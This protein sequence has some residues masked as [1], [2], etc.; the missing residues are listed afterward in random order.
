MKAFV[1]SVIKGLEKEREVVANAA[2]TLDFEVLRSEDFGALESSSQE[3]CLRGVRE[4]DVVL[5]ILGER[6]GRPQSSGRSATHEEYLEAR[7]RKPILA[8]VQEGVV[9]ED[10]QATLMREVEGWENG[11]S[12][13]RFRDSEDLAVKATQALH[14]FAVRSNA[15]VPDPAEALAR[16]ESF[17]AS[18]AN[19]SVPV[20]LVAVAGTTPHPIVRPSTLDDQKFQ[21]A[22]MREAQ[23][24]EPPVLCSGEGVE[25]RITG[26][27]LRI[28]QTNGQVLLSEDGSIAIIRP[29][30]GNERGR[31]G[32]M[33][34][35][36]EEDLGDAI[37]DCLKF[38]GKQLD[39]LDRFKRMQEVVILAGVLGGG[40]YGWQTRAEHQTSRGGIAI[41]MGGD[42]DRVLV[43]LMPAARMRASLTKQT[44]ELTEDLLALLRRRLR[45]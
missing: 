14:R 15:S 40:Y 32:W 28:E 1:S 39:A 42:R 21:K 27:V 7:E 18:M 4:A 22:I 38:I 17:V 12:T 37:R 29:T 10:A 44:D 45:P 11:V 5:L 43:H 3:A 8:F 24:G 41:G 34:V 13:A 2:T 26:H 30:R 16:A 19:V 31:M 33:P 36:I 9:P 25:C 20:V 23:Y 6:Y 35:L